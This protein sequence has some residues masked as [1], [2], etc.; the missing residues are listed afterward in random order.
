[1][2]TVCAI[3]PF[4]PWR[5]RFFLSQ[6]LR[7]PADQHKILLCQKREQ[8][9]KHLCAFQVM[10]PSFACVYVVP[11]TSNNSVTK[12]TKPHSWVNMVASHV[13]MENPREVPSHGCSSALLASDDLA[14][15]TSNITRRC[16]GSAHQAGR[17]APPQA[18]RYS[19]H[20]CQYPDQVNS[21]SSSDDSV[22]P[23][24]FPHNLSHI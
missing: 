20:G 12:S 6:H 7:K 10:V 21:A 22:V 4:V 14:G 5:R 18:L 3:L 13:C 24:F 1:M 8:L 15:T 11:N 9:S 23:N 16:T 17:G 19:L 2:A